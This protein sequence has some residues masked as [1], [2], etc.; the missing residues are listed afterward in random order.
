MNNELMIPFMRDATVFFYDSVLFLTGS[1]N[2][3]KNRTL[4]RQFAGLEIFKQV[5]CE[6]SL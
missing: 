5:V 6:R 4:V 1:I 3:L 2:K